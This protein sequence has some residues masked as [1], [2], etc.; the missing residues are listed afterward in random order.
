MQ[1]NAQIL[2]TVKASPK[3]AGALKLIVLRL[4]GEQ[5]RTAIK[6]QISSDNG[7]EGDRWGLK[8]D[9]NPLSQVSL[10]NARF[11]EA[12]AESPER[13]SLAGDNLII[14]F[15]IS[16]AN[17]PA[18]T[19]VRIGQTVIEITDLPHTACKKLHGRYGKEA[20]DLANSAEGMS[21]RLRGVYAKVVRGGEI[22]LGDKVHKEAAEPSGRIQ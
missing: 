4:L 1:D 8:P 21:L 2:N 12:F 9:A 15:D 22:R 20:T 3:D 5:R 19:R 10:M 11:L 17:L 16:E 18:G 6:A 13:M 7:V 14:D